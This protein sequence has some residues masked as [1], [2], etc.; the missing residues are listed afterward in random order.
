MV[1]GWILV[2][3]DGNGGLR[4]CD[5]RHGVGVKKGVKRGSEAETTL[6]RLF[7][8]L[9]HGLFLSFVCTFIEMNGPCSSSGSIASPLST[10]EVIEVAR[11]IHNYTDKRIIGIVYDPLVSDT[12]AVLAVALY[13][14][15]YYLRAVED[16]MSRAFAM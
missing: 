14:T 11:N 9:S 3:H 13:F 15:L 2:T 12:S 4:S 6:K 8:P 16:G 10:M 1:V 7:P 5:H